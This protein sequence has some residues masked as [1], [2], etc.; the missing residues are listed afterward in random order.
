MSIS[1]VVA[2]MQQRITLKAG[3]TYEGYITV[4][5]PAAATEDFLYKA[6]LSPYTVAG[7]D[8][9][10]DFLNESDWS[11]IVGWTKVED[12]EGSL[13][14]NETRKIK[15]SVKVPENAPAGGQYM[16]IRVSSNQPTS[17]DSGA[18]IQDVYELAAVIYAN[19]EGETVHEGK[20]LNNTMAGF[21]AVG[22]PNTSVELSNN[23]NVHEVATTKITIKD[24]FSGQTILPTDDIEGSYESIIMPETTRTVTRDL[25]MLSALG[26]YEVTQEVDY[27]GEQSS[28]TGIMVV[29]PIWFIA[30]VVATFLS[31]IGMFCYGRHLKHKK[32]KN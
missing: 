2:P 20:I 6:I 12:T 14:P 29:C 16:A 1:F 22:N 19:V 3:E 32:S 28:I 9:S 21:V 8:Y 4:T 7:A 24:V 17:S 25:D 23:G 31:V 13:K 27:M 26:I 30:L 15:F 18:A 10:P 11:R 5:N